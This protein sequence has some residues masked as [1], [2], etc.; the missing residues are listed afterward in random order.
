[1]NRNRVTRKEWILAVLLIVV[2]PLCYVS[3]AFAAEL[4]DRSIRLIDPKP[5]QN[6]SYVLAYNIQQSNNVGSVSYLF[7][8]NSPIPSQPCTAPAGLNVS[9]AAITSQIGEAGFAIHPNTNSNRIVLTRAATP[10]TTGQAQH[11]FSNVVNPSAVNQVVYVRISMH[12]SIDGSGGATDQGSVVFRTTGSISTQAYVPPFLVFCSGVTVALNCSS[13]TGFYID[14]GELQSSQANVGTSQYSGATNDFSGYTVRIYGTTLTSGN[15]TLPALATP[16]PS[17]AGVSQ[18]GINLRD[19]SFPDVGIERQGSGTSSTNAN[20]NI[21]N[22][23]KYTSGDLLSSVS[24]SSNYNRYTVSYLVN[25][26]PSQKA[27]VY[28]ST[29]TFIAVASF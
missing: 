1:M 5:S 3:G 18:F 15:E 8:S 10:T 16:S 9:G 22:Q 12:S 24:T 23:F 20:Y 29:F 14:L 17:T 2:V 4:I 27:G 11:V 7:C 28:S 6:T 21:I 25:V 13:S 19:N 26:S